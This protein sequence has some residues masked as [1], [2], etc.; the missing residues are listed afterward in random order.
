MPATD[1]MTR[2]G[3]AFI[4]PDHPGDV[5]IHAAAATS[6]QTTETNR[7]FSAALAEH[8]MY[9]TVAENIKQQILATAPHLF[10]NILADDDMGFADVTCAILLAHLRATYGVITS[11]EL[12]VNRAQLSSK[13]TP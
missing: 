12:E 11:E 5:P 4:T 2:A 13:W 7:Q 6:V 10:L 9:R 3:Q 8:T 1:Y